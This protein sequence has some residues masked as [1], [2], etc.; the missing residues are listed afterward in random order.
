MSELITTYKEHKE[1]PKEYIKGLG[2]ASAYAGLDYIFNLLKNDEIYSEE[3]EDGIIGIEAYVN[4]REKEIERLKEDIRV[5]KFTIKTQQE[6]IQELIAREDKAIEY[7]KEKTTDEETG[8]D[9]GYSDLIDYEY[10]INILQGVDK[11]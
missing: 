4:E 7:I 8:E 1:K 3:L 5:F 11:E 2:R 9:L 10:L 6:Q